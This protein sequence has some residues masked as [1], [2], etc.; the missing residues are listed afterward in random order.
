MRPSELAQAGDHVFGDG[1][2]VKGV[3]P[4][5]GNP[6]QRVRQRF[7]AVDAADGRRLAIDQKKATGGGI[8]AEKIGLA[9]PVE[10]DPLGNRV[11]VA[12]QMDGRLQHVAERSGAMVVQQLFPGI[13]GARNGDGKGGIAWD[14]LCSDHRPGAFQR[15]TAGARPEPLK[16]TIRSSP[17]GA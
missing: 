2:G 5:R 11:A 12:R 1:T 14:L 8:L 17:R 3:S 4:T 16:A 13:D 9:R 7:L 10:M 6:L 15:G